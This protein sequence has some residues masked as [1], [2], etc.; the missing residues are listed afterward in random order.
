MPAKVL[1]NPMVSDRAI[2]A[3]R[4]SEWVVSLTGFCPVRTPLVCA[5]S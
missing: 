3:R 2:L 4:A 1:R 5:A